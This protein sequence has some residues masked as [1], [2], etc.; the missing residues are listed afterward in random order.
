MSESLYFIAVIPPEDIQEQVTSL[1]HQVAEKFGSKHALK[2]PPHITLHMPFK[3]KEK[4]KPQLN[5][6]IAGINQDLKP[7]EVQLKDFDFFEPRVVFIDVIESTELEGLQKQVV[8]Q[9]RKELKLDNANY[10]DRP[11]H[12]HMTIAF[13]DLRKKMF[14]EARDFFNEKKF[15]RK[16]KVERV[17]LLKH[18]GV[19]WL[20]EI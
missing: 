9:C 13:R 11:F 3:W 7:F 20:I 14:N 6:V 19:R 17:S 8:D 5:G 10:R 16:F 12:S 2:S 15:S 18:D 1:K 4:K